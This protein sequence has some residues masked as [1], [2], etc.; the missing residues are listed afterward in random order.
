MILFKELYQ[1][2]IC[3]VSYMISN[4]NDCKFSI[5][6]WTNASWCWWPLYLLTL[7]AELFELSIR[8]MVA[9]GYAHRTSDSA[10]RMAA[11]CSALRMAVVGSGRRMTVMCSERP[12]RLWV[13]RGRCS[14]SPL[15]SSSGWMAAKV[16]SETHLLFSLT[17]SLRLSTFWWLPFC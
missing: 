4:H 13:L 14:R 5:T 17:L 6:C 3:T 10:R 1:H 12:W 7:V 16:P 15:N 2:D 11:V 8:R 9:V